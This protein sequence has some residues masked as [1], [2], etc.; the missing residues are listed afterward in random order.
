MAEQKF[1]YFVLNYWFPIKFFYS[2]WGEDVGNDN[3]VFCPFH[4]DREGGKPSGKIYNDEDGD[5]LYCFTEQKQ[6]RAVDFF[7]LFDKS[8]YAV[9]DNLWLSLTD[10]EKTDI[11]S[12]Y[13][14]DLSFARIDRDYADKLN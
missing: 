10:E 7:P 1:I 3:I 9:F 2:K 12:K 11:M 8:R 4:P 5:R 14:E 6:Y 13:G